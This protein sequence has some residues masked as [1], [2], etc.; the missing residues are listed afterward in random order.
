MQLFEMA[1]RGW[2]TFTKMVFPTKYSQK[3]LNIT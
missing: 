1:V 3:N 2:K